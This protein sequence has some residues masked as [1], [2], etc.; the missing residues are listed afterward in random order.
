[1][2]LHVNGYLVGTSQANL[3]AQEI[4]LRAILSVGYADLA[5]LQ[6]AGPYSSAAIVNNASI[7]GVRITDGPHFEE[8]QGAEF[9][10]LRRCRFTGSATFL[11]PG[12]AAVI[13]E[14]RESLS[15]FGNC[16]PQMSWRHPVN[17]GPILQQVF[18]STTM[19]V[20]QSGRAVG[21]LVRPPPQPP[22]FP[23]ITMHQERSRVTPDDPTRIGPGP[24]GL[25]NWPISWNYEFESAVP[26][27]GL[28]NLPPF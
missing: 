14:Y 11:C 12:T 17:T 21:H 18:P 15:F 4:N 9:V 27:V 25:I 22:M 7:S 6:D 5:L 20:V 10:T 2:D 13:V 23:L 28:P 19:R 16:G 26:L 24:A 1:M 3:T 8:A